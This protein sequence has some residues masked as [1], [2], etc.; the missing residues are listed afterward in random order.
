MKFNTKFLHTDHKKGL[1]SYATPS[2]Q[3]SCFLHSKYFPLSRQKSLYCI[4]LYFG[5]FPPCSV[6]KWTKNF[7]WMLPDL[8]SVNVECTQEFHLGC[9]GMW[10][11]FAGVHVLLC[12]LPPVLL[13]VGVLQ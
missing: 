6:Y 5:Q 12:W 4:A 2:F 13:P 7:V 10:Y 8:E 11:V 3:I 9:V 1:V